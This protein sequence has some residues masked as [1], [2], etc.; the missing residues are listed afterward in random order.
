MTLNNHF[1]LKCVSGSATNEL[2]FLAF[3]ILLKTVEKFVELPI[4]CQR[5]NCSP[6]ILVSSKARCMLKIAGFAGEGAMRVMR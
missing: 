4:H 3:A 6:G 5:Q 1:A 2:A